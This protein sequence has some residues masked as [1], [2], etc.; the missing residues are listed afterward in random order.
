MGSLKTGI[1]LPTA[2]DQGGKAGRGPLFVEAR[3]LVHRADAE[4]GPFPIGKLKKK[5]T[6]VD[7]T[8]PEHGAQRWK[9]PFS[10]GQWTAIKGL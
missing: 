3:H 1:L 6:Y 7:V 4:S 10:S 2:R 9:F 5:R 8:K